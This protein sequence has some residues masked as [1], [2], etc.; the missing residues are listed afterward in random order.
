MSFSLYDAIVPTFDQTLGAIT[1]LLGKA[2]AHCTEK[3]LDPSTVLQTRLADDMLPFTYQVKSTA[4]HSIGAIEGV[5][6][7][8]FHPD[9]TPPPESFAGL[10]EK[11]ESARAALS[12]VSR[13]E[14][15]SFEG[16]DVRFE[17][18]DRKLP[19]TAENFLLSFSFPNF[20]FHAATAHGILRHNGVEIGKRDFLGVR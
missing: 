10:R 13:D 11:I 4:V 14:V 17:I 6:K 2:E 19:F 3:S 12:A 16:R 1:H 9:M 8:V 7:G 5:R 20:Y 18:G 15:D